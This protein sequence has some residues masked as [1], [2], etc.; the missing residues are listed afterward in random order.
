V[1]ASDAVPGAGTAAGIPEPKG[2][3]WTYVL[4]H[5]SWWAAANQVTSPSV[6]VH[7]EAYKPSGA[8]DGVEWEFEIQWLDGRIRVEFDEFAECVRIERPDLL[9]AISELP[10]A[11]TPEQVVSVLARLGFV[12]TTDRQRPES[13]QVPA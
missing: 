11:A 4:A 12:D 5:E 13:L 10:S 2:P 6:Y 9:H 7:H 1:T 8:R 3:A